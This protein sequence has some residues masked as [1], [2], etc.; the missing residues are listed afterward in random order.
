MK[1]LLLAR[2][3]HSTFLYESLKKNPTIDITYHTFSIFKKGSLLN[4]WKPS[5]KSVDSEVEIS[6]GFTFFHRLLDF[7]NK[8]ITFDYYGTENK[9][10][11]HFFKQILEKYQEEFDVVHYW[12]IYC[13]Q[14]VSNFQQL[15][16]RTKL[17]VEVYAAHPDY[18]REILEP[19]YD[20]YG[21]SINK[22]HF[23]K[24]RD[25]DVASLEGVKNILVPS[26]YMAKIYQKYY[27]ETKIF[28]AGYGLLHFTDKGLVQPQR[29]DSAI[30][31][32]LFVGKISI[33]KGCI[34]LLEAMKR[35]SSTEFQLD[36]IGEIEPSQFFVFKPYFNVSNIKFLGKLPNDKIL[37]ILPNYHIFVLPSLTD[38][39]SLAVSEALAHKL[40]VIITENVGTKNEIKK[41]EIG[42]VCQ[43]KDSNSL[44]EAILSLQNE[45][46]RQTLIKNIDD[47]IVDNQQNPYSAKVLDIY[48]YLLK[49]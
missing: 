12:P 6:Y 49:N 2:P 27:P 44:A 5:V 22:S 8:Q 33:E 25:R 13:H 29:R 36:L 23:I 48:N 20:K 47:F 39:Y 40:P 35:L 30:L 7:L 17:L 3:D 15:N 42:I 19:D 31:K 24:S 46:Y 38:A 9:I 1:T 10:S 41:F 16:P 37:E 43:I 4:R 18:V 26:E 11:E 14:A 28:T 21:I 45:E 34:Y 32:L